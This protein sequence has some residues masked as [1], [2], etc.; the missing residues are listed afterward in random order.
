MLPSHVTNACQRGWEGAGEGHH[1]PLLICIIDLQVEA[2]EDMWLRH[3][4]DEMAF[5]LQRVASEESWA[6]D[7][8]QQQAGWS[9]AAAA[10]REA[11]RIRSERRAQWLCTLQ[12]IDDE[13]FAFREE[14]WAQY[15]R[16]MGYWHQ[17]HRMHL[18]EDQ[19]RQQISVARGE[20]EARWRHGAQALLGLHASICADR[21]L[22]QAKV[23]P[24]HSV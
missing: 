15:I 19:E 8:L 4:A 9:I 20:Q 6:W 2:W 16:P 5:E 14:C 11:E 22:V 10:A 18:A 12:D 3:M 17:Q 23:L 24:M 1:P 13:E 7:A 21:M